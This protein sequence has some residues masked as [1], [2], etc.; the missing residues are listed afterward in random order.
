MELIVQINELVNGFVW[1]PIM[2]LLLVG[3][4]IYFTFRL[5]FFQII[6]ISLWM[7]NTFGKLFHKQKAAK[8]AVTPFQALTTALAATVGTGNMVGVATAIVE[9]GP[10]AIF[11]MWVSAFFGMMT[12]YSE[13]TLSLTYRNKNKDGEWVGGPM[14]YIR[15]GLGKKFNGLAIV[16]AA[17]GAL[18]AFGIG[19]MTQ[20]N[21]ISSSIETLFVQLRILPNAA[22]GGGFSVFKLILGILLALLVGLVIL[23]GVKRIGGVTEM[24]VPFMSVIYILGAVTVLVL[25]SKLISPAFM[26]IIESAF[27][28]RSAVGGVAGYTISRAVRFGIARGVF[29]NEAGLGSAPIAHAAADTDSPVKQGMWG[30]FEVFVDTFVICTLTALVILTSGVYTGPDSITG[31]PL[32]IASYSN[33]FGIWGT[34]FVTI[35]ITLFAF[36]TVLGWSLYGQRCFEF[37]FKGRG[38]KG[39]QTVFVLCVVVSSVMRLGLAWDISDTLNGL[40]AIP[41]LIALFALS[42]TVITLTKKFL[43]QDNKTEINE[44]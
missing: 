11:W 3:V 22:V 10:G 42:G 37:L 35:A 32:T 13:I 8:G 5:R 25:H 4:G 6:H 21:S 36:S 14:Y 23:G 31:T 38:I 39:Y 28:V 43:A 34:V 24:L 1:G 41:N 19:N 30:I 16:F 17:L 2:L 20:I 18:A 26:S 29:S 15:N 40:M 12:K 9:G 33:T 44:L 7:K 27:S